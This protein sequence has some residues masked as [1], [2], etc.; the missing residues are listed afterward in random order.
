ML[1]P[2]ERRGGAM[3]DTELYRAILGPTPP[4]TVGSGELEMSARQMIVPAMIQ[5]STNGGAGNLTAVR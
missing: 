4:W 2:A 3:R 5:V 1:R